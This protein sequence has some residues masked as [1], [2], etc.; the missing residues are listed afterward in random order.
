MNHLFEP[1][2]SGRSNVCNKRRRGT[3]MAIDFHS[4]TN[5]STYTG[6]LADAGWAGAIRHIVDPTGKRV[7]DIGCGG[8]IYSR[9]WRELGAHEVVGVDFSD[10]T[11]APPREQPGGPPPFSLRHGGRPT[12][13]PP[14]TA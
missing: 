11:V 6:R 9:A 10:A 4:R 8:G 12:S 14:T 5:R 1:M 13:P 2:K 7:A 3:R